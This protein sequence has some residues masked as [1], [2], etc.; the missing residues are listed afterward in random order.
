M[1]MPDLRQ[2]W[3]QHPRHGRKHELQTLARMVSCGFPAQTAV[4]ISVSENLFV[5]AGVGAGAVVFLHGMHGYVA[6]RSGGG[7]S[8][9]LVGELCLWVEE[10]MSGIGVDLQK[11]PA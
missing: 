11:C 7:I 2:Q 6:K 8:G 9:C 5:G 4:Q 10:R 1:R 3:Q